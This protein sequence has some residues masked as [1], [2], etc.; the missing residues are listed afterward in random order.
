[1]TKSTNKFGKLEKFELIYAVSY[2]ITGKLLYE[3]IGSG[4]ASAVLFL[5]MAVFTVLLIV[6]RKHHTYW[7][8]KPLL[9]VLSIYY[10]SLTYTIV[11]F[12]MCNYPG[13]AALNITAL[14][15]FFIYSVLAYFN[16]TQYNQ[17]LN[18][19]LYLQMVAFAKYG[20]LEDW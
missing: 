19:Y 10:K 13:K 11:I 9:T 20:L 14:A 6:L 16:R 7:Q 18:A 12:T 15:S 4:L 8:D 17:M 2:L 5:C 1:M 3:F